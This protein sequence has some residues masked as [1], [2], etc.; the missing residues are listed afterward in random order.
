MKAYENKNLIV[1]DRDG[2]EFQ[3]RTYRKV[4]LNDELDRILSAIDHYWPPASEIVTSAIRV[5]DD[6]LRIIRTYMRAKGL[7][8]KYPEAMTCDI[9]D[10]GKDIRFGDD[11]IYAWQPGWSALLNAGVIVNPPYPAV[12][13]M[14]YFRSGVNKKG[15]TIGQSPHIRGKAFDL[16]GLDSLTIVKRLVEDGMIRGYLLER[17]NNCLHIDI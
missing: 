5:P 4:V 1:P 8:K 17:E 16:S 14:D 10:K 2:Y 3:G 9:L 7:D 15:Q 11:L 12:A 6:S 13:L